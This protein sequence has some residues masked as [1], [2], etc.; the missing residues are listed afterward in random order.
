MRIRHTAARVGFTAAAL[1]ATSACG[2]EGARTAAD[3]VNNAD[4]IMAALA[5]A[6]DRTEEVGSAEVRMTTELGTGDP[7]AM[8]GTYS[9]GDGFAFDVEM[10][11]AAAR[12]QQLTD[13]PTIRTLFVDGAYYYDVDPQP[14]G[15][16][17]GKEWMRIDGSAVFGEQGADALSGSAGGSPSASMRG[18]RY[19]SD[20]EDL[21]EETVG[22][23]STTHY[24]A[25]IDQDGMG[26][27]KE[28][29]GNRD[30]LLNS[31]TGG[32]DSMTM[33]VWVGAG[34]LPV[35]MTQTYGAMKVT[36]D[37]DT[38]GAAE[39]IQA[40]PAARTGDLTDQVKKAKKAAGR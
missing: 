38:F 7:I 26:R 28:A 18:L 31:M 29:L 22:G 10:D 8:D 27:F 16:L 24:R 11:T 20:V 35:R 5:R 32:A 17:Q 14:A 37:F 6:T 39:E 40:P 4:T 9:W 13:S 2:A 19:A 36:M 25:V 23:K 33:E 21:G 1:V 12:M 30:S 15:P 3:A 34:D